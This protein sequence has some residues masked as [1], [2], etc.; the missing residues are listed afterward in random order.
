M[1][2]LC[3]IQGFSLSLSGKEPQNGE[4]YKPDQTILMGSHSR[5]TLLY[6]LGLLSWA[7]TAHV[8]EPY[9]LILKVK[10]TWGPWFSGSSEEVKDNRIKSCA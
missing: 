10:I 4:L 2:N 9:F 1:E 3:Y 8:S 6:S 5:G 7:L